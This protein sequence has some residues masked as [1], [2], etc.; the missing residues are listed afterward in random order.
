VQQVL[1]KQLGE[2]KCGGGAFL[3]ACGFSF[4]EN[5]SSPKWLSNEMIV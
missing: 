3:K 4:I 1:H 5:K 2:M